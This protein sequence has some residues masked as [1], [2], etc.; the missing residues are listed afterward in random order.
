MYNYAFVISGVVVSL[1]QSTR[2]VSD[3]NLVLIE[4]YDESLLGAT[5]D[6]TNFEKQSTE[7]PP[8]RD[9][10]KGAFYARL[11]FD[12]ALALE[13][14]KDANLAIRVLDRRLN[15]RSHVNLDFPETVQGLALLV[16]A[17]IIAPERVAVLLADGS[18]DEEF[19]V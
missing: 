5:W 8:I 14:A 3:D 1:Q 6:G 17:K 16:D 13:A 12:E 10:S 9:I 15:L 18:P 2:P 11:T 4:T 7:T 19:K